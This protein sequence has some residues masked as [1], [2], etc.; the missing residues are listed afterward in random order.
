MK[1]GAL[2]DETGRERPLSQSS[3]SSFLVSATLNCAN[4][5][6]IQFYAEFRDHQYTLAVSLAYAVKADVFQ[7]RARHYPSA[8]EAALFPDDVP[9]AVYDGLIHLSARIETAVSIF[10]FSPARPRFAGAASLRHVRSPR[11]ED[12]D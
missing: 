12:P 5:R 11:S 10:R 7:A 2:V 8:L 3:F 9:V 4:T 6:F 1:F